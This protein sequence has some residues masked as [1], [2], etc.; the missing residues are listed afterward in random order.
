MIDKGKLDEIINALEEMGFVVLDKYEYEA[1][2]EERYL[3]GYD[4]CYEKYGLQEHG[5]DW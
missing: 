4:A 2:L 3:N 1:D 5:E